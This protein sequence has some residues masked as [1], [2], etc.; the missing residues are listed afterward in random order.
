MAQFPLEAFTHRE[1][2]FYFYDMALLRATLARIV[3]VAPQGSVVHYALKA[4]SNEALL[5]V[6]AAAG[7]GADCVSGGEVRLAVAAG[8]SAANIVYSGVG[9][10]DKEICESLRL[11]IGCFNVESVAEI[12]VID[13]LAQRE[14]LTAPIAL[15]INPHIDA[16]THHYITTGLSENKFGIDITLLD[17]VL[18][19]VL[20]LRHVK[21]RGLHFHIGS[22]I[23]DMTAYK[24]LCATVNQLIERLQQQKVAIDYVNVGGG[25]GVDYEEPDENAIPDFESYFGVFSSELSLPAG[26][27]L[28]FELG[29]SVVCQCGSLIARVLYI[30]EG[31]NKQFAIL[32]A[33]MNDLMRPALYQASHKIENIS[34]VEGRMQCYDVV[35]P[36]C[37][38]SD[39]FGSGVAMPELR[40]GDFIAIR[41]AGAYGESM[42]MQ[43]NARELPGVMLW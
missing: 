24:Q 13:E 12:D 31:V 17:D 5:R 25:L 36:I 35:G 11:G 6:I 41:S 18:L 7:L 4:N 37:E 39:S 14:G 9:K 43:Y 28:H 27:T 23:T 42:A 3:S 15:R 30:K 10:T 16:H 22:Q 20:S 21:L 19:H 38:S 8:I 2:P 40:R 32:D 33:G 1:T 34:S 26:V 29:R